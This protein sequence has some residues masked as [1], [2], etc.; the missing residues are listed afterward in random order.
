MKTDKILFPIDLAK[1]P[2]DAFSLVNDFA[3]RPN[4]TLILLHVVKLNILAP[5]NRV[6]EELCQE[7]EWQLKQLAAHYVQPT[8]ETRLRVRVGNPSEEIMAEAAEQQVNLIVLPLPQPSFW[9]RLLA[10]ILPRTTGKLMEKAPCP[11]F[12]LPVK[13]LFNCEEHWSLGRE[14]RAPQ[15]N[16]PAGISPVRASTQRRAELCAGE[17]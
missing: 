12:A 16:R 10:P 9:K 3:A 11:V 6:Y 13:N 14:V 5:E 8:V 17:V 4:A 15:G 1:C 7:A 2:L